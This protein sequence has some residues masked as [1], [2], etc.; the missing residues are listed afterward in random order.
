MRSDRQ[1]RIMISSRCK[2]KIELRG[3]D[4][5]YSTLRKEIKEKIIAIALFGEP[6]FECWINEDSPASEGTEI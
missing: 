4:I 3:H 5:E 6:L 1:I 2:D